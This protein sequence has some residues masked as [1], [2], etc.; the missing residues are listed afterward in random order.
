MSHV[1]VYPCPNCRSPMSD[2]AAATETRQTIMSIV[3]DGPA[4]TETPAVS[5][6]SDEP[7]TTEMGQTADT[8]PPK[9]PQLHQPDEIGAADSHSVKVNR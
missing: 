8:V 5:I 3:S 6:V 4:A 7:A 2:K 9:K 1:T